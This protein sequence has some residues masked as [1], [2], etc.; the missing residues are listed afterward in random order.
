MADKTDAV[1][2]AA[3]ESDIEASAELAEPVETV[4]EPGATL[5]PVELVPE[6][7]EPAPTEIGDHVPPDTP[8]STRERVKVWL[9]ETRYFFSTL[10]HEVG[11][12]A[13]EIIAYL[14]ARL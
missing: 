5:E 10:E 8:E 7:P 14:K 6:P 3:P 9:A 12:S 2:E 13:G 1:A 11:G 4:A